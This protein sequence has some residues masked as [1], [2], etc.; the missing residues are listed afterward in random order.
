MRAAAMYTREAIVVT[1][2]EVSSVPQDR[3]RVA[4]AKTKRPREQ[5]P[6]KC[7]L[8]ITEY[9]PHARCGGRDSQV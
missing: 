2:P 3:S 4:H 5:N 8:L 1:N 7:H 6:V 9:S